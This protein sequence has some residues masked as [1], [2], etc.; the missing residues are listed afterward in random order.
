MLD[1]I[2]HRLNLL[3]LK[4][5]RPVEHLLAGEYQSIF[6][7]RGLEFE[8]VRAYQY[9]DD[10]R[11]MDWKVT[12]RTGEPHIKRYIEEREQVVYLLVDVS[13]SMRHDN[14]GNKRETLT[15]LCALITLAAIK[16]QDRVG[17][18]LFSDQIEQIIMP[19]KGR[20]HAM[21]IIDELINFKPT[22]KKTDL[23]S[24]LERFRLLSR[25]YSIVFLI[26][27]FLT[28]PNTLELQALSSIHDLNAIQILHSCLKAR[29]MRALIRIEDAETGQQ[30]VIDSAHQ[31]TQQAAQQAQLKEEMLKAGVNLMQIESGSDCVDALSAYFHQRQRRITDESGG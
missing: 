20:R 28:D 27:D 23:A 11:A 26:S 3:E 30:Q 9:G 17:L 13:A 24:M 6:R 2:A 4:C 7:G 29:Q 18:I 21:R 25:K 14:S 31:Y 12:A 10:V 19:S 5:R 1:H 8:D 22:N 16:N 15:E